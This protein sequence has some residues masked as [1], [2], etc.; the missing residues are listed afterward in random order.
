MAD[1]VTAVL[2]RFSVGDISKAELC[3]YAETIG[4]RSAKGKVLNEESIN[5]LL[6]S[7]EHAGY[8]HDK[9]TSYETVEGKHPGLITAAT[10]ER[11][12]Q[13]LYSGKN[14]R[15]GEVHLKDNDEFIVKGLLLCFNCKNPLYASAPRTGSGGR[16]PRYHC[17]RPTCRGKVASV[18]AEAVHY[19][20][21]LLL[22][23]MT[24]E[25]GTLRLYKEIL[26]RE[27]NNRL[28]GLNRQVDVLRD[29]LSRIAKSRSAAIAKYVED[30]LTLEEKNQ[31]VNDLDTQKLDVAAHLE[32]LEHQQSVR[33]ADI[34]RAINFMT[35]TAAQWQN[36]APDVKR[37]FQN[38]MFPEGL[39]Y[40]ST[41]RRF[42]TT[43]I[44][45]LYRCI[46]KEKDAEASDNS[47]L[48]AGAGLEPATSW[49]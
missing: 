6:A 4:L 29:R 39:V 1:K 35:N 12:Q 31:L 34:E 15:K 8:V 32:E 25:T 19:D 41:N 9:F 42:G 28:V 46:P 11:N 5:R 20:F 44:S 22:E 18:K 27:A 30:K 48:V 33:E 23:R 45:S 26:V 13:L 16:S 7:P 40:D 37:R 10:F 47:H 14:A 36:S 24:P 3:R 49:L 38:M 17:A 21:L 43:S 2:E